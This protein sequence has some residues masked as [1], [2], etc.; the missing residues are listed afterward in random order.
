MDVTCR[1]HLVAGFGESGVQ[2]RYLVRN[3]AGP[4]NRHARLRSLHI[5]RTSDGIHAQASLWH[6]GASWWEDGFLARSYLLGFKPRPTRGPMG[7]RLND[8]RQAGNV[9]LALS[10]WALS[11]M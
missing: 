5:T 11:Q 8:L 2:N 1:W 4:L 10:C 9:D 3:V 6:H 7:L